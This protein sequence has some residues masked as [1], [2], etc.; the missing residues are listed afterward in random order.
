MFAHRPNER[1]SS[2]SL[3]QEGHSK[4]SR[5]TDRIEIE[6]KGAREIMNQNQ[7]KNV[8]GIIY[9]YTHT[10]IEYKRYVCSVHANEYKKFIILGS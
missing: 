7:R 8:N 4:M 10:E 6:R 5:K 9:I 1:S 3:K 2:S